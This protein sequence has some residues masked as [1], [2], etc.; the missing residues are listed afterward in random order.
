MFNR[1]I[2]IFILSLIS[3]T[4]FIVF[5]NLDALSTLPDDITSSTP[6]SELVEVSTTTTTVSSTTTT[7]TVPNTT[8]T[9]TVPDTTTSSTTT[10][11][12]TTT[13]TTVPNTTTTTTVPDTTTSSTT[14]VPVT[15]TTTVPLTTTT[16]TTTTT[17]PP[18]TTTTT[19]PQTTVNI[20]VTVANNGYGSN[21]YFLNGSQNST[22]NVSSGNKYRFDQS[23]I[24][25]SGHPMRF[26]TS[27]DGSQYTI[28]VTTNGVPGTA[29]SFIE[30]EI[31]SET[32]NLLYILCTNH[33]GM[34]GEAKIIKN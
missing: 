7:T 20:T 25:N 10:V 19:V 17:V 1:Y 31:T 11:P 26:S 16:S 3:G 23:D 29:G 28:N 8:I 24:T 34:G 21:L 4:G 13:T 15:T 9:T 33:F 18:T 6:A 2:L 14:T 30:I 22:I 12:D 27:Q 32:P 5:N